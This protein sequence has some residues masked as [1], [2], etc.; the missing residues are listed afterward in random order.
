MADFE[1]EFIPDR[2]AARADA[3]K[4]G[5]G[6]SDYWTMKAFVDAYR[7]GESSPVDLFRALDCSLPGLIAL[8]S[9]KAGGTPIEVPDPRLFT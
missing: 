3:A 9:A 6:G 8:Q 1:E 2:V 5:H 4:T 7:S